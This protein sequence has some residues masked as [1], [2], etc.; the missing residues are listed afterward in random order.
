MA[1][2][3]VLYR[4]R[5]GSGVITKACLPVNSMIFGH[6][7]SCCATY[8]PEYFHVTSISLFDFLLPPFSCLGH[9][10][11]T[12]VKPGHPYFSKVIVIASEYAG[13]EPFH[14]SLLFCIDLGRRLGPAFIKTR[15][16]SIEYHIPIHQHVYLPT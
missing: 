7:S 10:S 9:I 12:L 13:H 16:A 11:S 1:V 5:V 8:V 15:G 3:S 6:T 14:L 4:C 2:V